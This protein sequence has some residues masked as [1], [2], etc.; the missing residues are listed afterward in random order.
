LGENKVGNRA[1]NIKYVSTD[2]NLK[3]SPHLF[4]LQFYT[5]LKMYGYAKLC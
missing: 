5:L 4:I 3:K 2:E 1:E